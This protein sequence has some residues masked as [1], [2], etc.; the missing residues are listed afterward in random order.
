MQTI[1]TA[2]WSLGVGLLLSSLGAC[3][4]PIGPDQQ[5]AGLEKSDASENQPGRSDKPGYQ[6]NAR[7]EPP[8]PVDAH[9]TSKHA[10]TDAFR[11]CFDGCAD[12]SGDARLTCHNNCANEVSAGDNG[13]TASAC[14]RGC[15]QAFGACLAPCGEKPNAGDVASCRMHCQTVA[16]ACVDGCS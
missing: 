12:T 6:P 8:G 15:M 16:E 9:S 13:P 5:E 4:A 2:M 14:P 3:G 7:A 10:I 11:R 1:E